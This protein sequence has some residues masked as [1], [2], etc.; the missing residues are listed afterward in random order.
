M[1][2]TLKNANNITDNKT[3]IILIMKCN[4]VF[5]FIFL[6]YLS[7]PTECSSTPT[8]WLQTRVTLL[9]DVSSMK[10]VFMHTSDYMKHGPAVP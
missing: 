2:L 7:E 6:N 4:I 9:V 3:V 10:V 5:H 8:K 1:I